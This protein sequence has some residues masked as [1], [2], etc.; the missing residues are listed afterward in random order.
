MHVPKLAIFVG[1]TGAFFTLRESFMPVT[2]NG[3]VRWMHHFNLSIDADKAFEL[4]QYHSSHMG[5]ELI[6]SRERLAE[7]M[8]EIQRA[9]SDQLAA[10]QR[11]IAE[12][13][14]AQEAF[15]IAIHEDQLA[16]LAQGNMPIGRFADTPLGELPISYLNW[17]ATNTANF[18]EGSILQLTSLKLNT[19]FSHL[20]LPIPHKDITVGEVKKRT[21][22]MVCVIKSIAFTR[23]A[24]N[25]GMEYCFV[26]TMCS[27]DGACIVS[28]TPSFHPEVGEKFKMKATVKEFKE[29]NGQMQTIVQRC[30]VQS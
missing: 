24:F 13:T 22:F 4:A 11:K 26:T 1:E 7:E 28:I 23:R 3:E 10:R 19:E 14:A 16:K 2:G 21:E 30:T 5:I 9:T 29:Y 6:T 18:D 27:T 17:L 15:L 8:R 20:L 12:D 25:G